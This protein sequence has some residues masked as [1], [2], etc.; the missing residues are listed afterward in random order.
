MTQ[1][2]HVH[3]WA[4]SSCEIYSQLVCNIDDTNAKEKHYFKYICNNS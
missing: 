3:N 1:C 2:F 4:A